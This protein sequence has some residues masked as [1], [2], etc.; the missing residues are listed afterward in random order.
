MHVAFYVIYQSINRSFPLTL[1]YRVSG[2]TFGTLLY[3]LLSSMQLT[4]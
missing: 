2:P 1:G 3:G 4:E